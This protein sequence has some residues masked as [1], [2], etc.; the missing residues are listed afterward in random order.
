MKQVKISKDVVDSMLRW[1]NSDAL[2]QLKVKETP[3]GV[4]VVD[5]EVVEASASAHVAPAYP[6]SIVAPRLGGDYTVS[7]ARRAWRKAIRGEIEKN[8]GQE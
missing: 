5:A 6:R 3:K 2:V 1:T 8:D 4:S 7:Q